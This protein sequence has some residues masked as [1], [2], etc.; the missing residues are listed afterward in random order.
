M[1][2]R[3]FDYRPPRDTGLVAAAIS[4]IVPLVPGLSLQAQIKVMSLIDPESKT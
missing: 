3:F 4:A 1:S 2:C